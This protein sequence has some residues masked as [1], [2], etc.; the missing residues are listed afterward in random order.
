MVEMER[1][2]LGLVPIISDVVMRGLR[3]LRHEQFKRYAPELFPL[4][5]E[6]TV[7]NSREVREKVREV[8]SQQVG[9]IVGTALPAAPAAAAGAGAGAE[10][11]VAPS[12]PLTE[13]TC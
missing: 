4:L 1:E 7:V 10:D 13:T 3:D 12:S 5:C 9:P 2:V 6:L 8:L 11:G